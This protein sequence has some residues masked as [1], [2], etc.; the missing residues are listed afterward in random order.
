MNRRVLATIVIL[1]ASLLLPASAS[2]TSRW[3]VKNASGK[4]LGSVQKS[5]SGAYRYV[6][7]GARV[8]GIKYWGGD[9]T[10]IAWYAPPSAGH[11]LKSILVTP[12]TY[13]DPDP[14]RFNMGPRTDYNVTGRAVRR[15]GRWVV[16]RRVSGGFWHTRGR[17]SSSCPGGVAGGAVFVLD[18]TWR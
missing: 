2:A 3:L 4:I 15:S 10:A 6:R 9:A 7:A 18:K 16:Q 13:P 5:S 12:A 8:G 1:S 17:V 14:S 11:W